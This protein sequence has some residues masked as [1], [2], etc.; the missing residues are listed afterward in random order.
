MMRDMVSALAATVALTNGSAALAQGGYPAK[1][2]RM[3]VPFAPGGNTDII[4][5]AISQKMTEDLGQ[6][7]VIDNRGGAA[8]TLGTDL[9]A[10]SPP[11]GYTLLMVSSAHVINPAVWKKLPYDSVKDFAPVTLVANVPNSLCIHP[12]V[13]AKNVKELVA[14]ARTK[15]D[16]LTYATPGRGTSSHLAIEMLSFA[17]SIKLIH[18]PYKGVGPA[19]IDLVAGHVHMMFASMPTT[20]PHVH[21]GR[22]RMI[23]QAGSER[24]AAARSVPTMIEQGLKDFVVISGFG[25]FAPAG[26]P[27]AI[28]DRV[29][30]SVKKSLNYPEINA[31]LASQGAEPVANTPDEYD[32][33]NR[34]EI[35]RWIDV[36]RK[37]GV[38]PE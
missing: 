25:M 32:R 21:T 11:D 28:V 33:Y 6:S 19:A 14:L 36:A 7:V 5:R 9:A 30:A 17:T 27:R 2:I 16:Q 24:S 38:Q 12:S 10:K 4:A 31:S 15:P 35:A 34:T 20:M 1:A 8:S 23:A 37:A 29:Y 26:T 18:V 22:L 3:I 13:P